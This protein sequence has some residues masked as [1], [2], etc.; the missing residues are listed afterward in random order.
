M[1]DRSMLQVEGLTFRYEDMQMVFDLTLA[2][3][4]CLAVLGPSGAGKSTL[5]SLIAGFEKPLSGRVLVAGEDVTQRKPADRPVTS[6]FQE[7]NLFAHLTVEQNVGLGLDP[8]LRLDAAQRHAVA[9]ELARVGLE[10]LEKRRPAQLSGGQRQRVAL[11]R[12]L[13]RDKPLLLLD[14]PFSALD[15]GLRLE[16]LDLLRQLQAERNLTVVMVSHN[17]QDARRIAGET[18][19]VCDGRIVAAGP[20]EALLAAREPAALRAFLGPE[21]G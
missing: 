15:P 10:G 18:A 20:T 9:G 17:P 16:M 12:S 11:A 21:A 19:F 8:G 2:R 7:H 14:E 6:L 3:G 4:Q 13:V 1:S 5:L